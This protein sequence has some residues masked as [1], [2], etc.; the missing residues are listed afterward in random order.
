MAWRVF[1]LLFSKLPQFS[2]LTLR[3]ATQSGVG[4][5]DCVSCAAVLW[6]GC[7]PEEARTG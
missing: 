4:C 7:L 2:C 3:V 6:T 1:F 5:V